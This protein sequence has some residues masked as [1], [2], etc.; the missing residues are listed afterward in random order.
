ARRG[1]VGVPVRDAAPPVERTGP[2]PVVGGEQGRGAGRARGGGGGRLGGGGRGAHGTDARPGG[3]G[4]PRRGPA[5]GD[6]VERPAYGG[7]VRRDPRDRRS[8]APDRDH[9]Q[10]R[11]AGV[12][13][14][15]AVVAATPRARDLGGDR[16]R[17]SPQGPRAAPTHRRARRGPRRRVRDDV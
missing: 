5:P 15:Q 6:P 12:H 17:A 7:R 11:P 8:P 10:R 3:A 9:G 4:H 14:T 2:G 13:G 16:A 1:G